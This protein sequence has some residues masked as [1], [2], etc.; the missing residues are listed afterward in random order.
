MSTAAILDRAPPS[1]VDAEMAIIGS[2][3][4]LPDVIDEISIL[5]IPEDFYDE[6]NAILFRVLRDM[7]EANKR[8]DAKLLTSSLKKAKLW[9]SSGGTSYLAKCIESVASAAH[10]V[11]YAKIVREKATY[12]RLIGFATDTLRE[13]YNEEEN[14]EWLLGQAEARVFEMADRPDDKPITDIG[15]AFREAMAELEAREQGRSVGLATGFDDLDDALAGLHA[16]EL[17]ILAARPSMGKSALAA[18][19]AEYVAVQ[20]EG[21]VYYA[22]LEMN[23]SQ[24]AERIMLGRAKVNAFDAR[25]GNLKPEDRQAIIEAAAVLSHHP[26]FYIDDN[27]GATVRLIASQ[28]RRI[29]RK[30]GLDLLIVDYLQLLEPLD[31]NANREQQVAANSK[32]LKRLAGELKVPVLCVAQLNRQVDMRAKKEPVLSDLRESGAIEQDADAVLMIHRP[33]YYET[34][35]AAQEVAGQAVVFIRKQRN[36]P[37]GQVSLRWRKEWTLFESCA[38][39]FTSKET[40]GSIF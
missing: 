33:E 9:E 13:A 26:R 25:R 7:H 29:K 23:Q 3:L 40:Q 16:G 1:D 12:R 18:N 28:A 5:V 35:K 32:A 36:G 34:G 30:H 6:A 31:R 17:V 24:L 4:L 22:S 21:S 10:A 14:A 19:I 39:D 20:Q 2:I 37:L 27:P 15:D 11:H 38:E 8:I